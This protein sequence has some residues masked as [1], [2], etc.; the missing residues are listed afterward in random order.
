MKEVKRIVL[1]KSFD[2]LPKEE[3]DRILEKHRLINV[4][5]GDWWEFVVDDV[6]EEFEEKYGVSID[7]R[8]LS[9]DLYR[10][11][12]SMPFEIRDYEKFFNKYC[13]GDENCVKELL[14]VFD[15]NNIICEPYSDSFIISFEEFD[16]EIEEYE[17]KHGVDLRSEFQE[18][19]TELENELFNQLRDEYDYLISDE[20]VRETLIANDFGV[21]KLLSEE[22][23]VDE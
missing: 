14:K 18:V 7:E 12:I 11:D 22:V 8:R 20:A 2:D 10:R 9:F 15:Y 5:S 13:N 6:N 17:K 23:I 21:E 3:Q 19:I 16:D 4:E 1:I